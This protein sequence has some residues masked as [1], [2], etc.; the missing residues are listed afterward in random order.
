LALPLLVVGPETITKP[1]EIQ[2][3][4]TKNIITSLTV[5]LFIVG[6]ALSFNAC[7]EQSPLSHSE[8]A[9]T[10]AVLAKK[11]A[12]GGDSAYPQTGVKSYKLQKAAD[13]FYY[14]SKAGSIMLGNGSKFIV[15]RGALK[16][17]MPGG[18]LYVK[19]TAYYDATIN[20]LQ[21]VF[22]P[23]G[24]QFSPPAEVWLNYSDLNISSAKLY[25]IDDNG[26]YIEQ[27]PADVDFQGSKMKVYIDH[28]SRYA[29]GME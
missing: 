25:Y 26:D 10:E 13:G 14:N 8:N 6:M 12:G 20:E 23:H 19:M 15:E 5:A 17:P 16:S 18:S 29:I 21:F 28:F 9:E 4:T 3:K 24:A 7:S 11:P 2:M 27:Q 1:L 22:T